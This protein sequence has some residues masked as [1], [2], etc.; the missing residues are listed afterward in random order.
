MLLGLMPVTECFCGCTLYERDNGTDESPTRTGY[1]Y[2]SGIFG[3][4]GRY[5]GKY[6]I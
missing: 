5:A 6:S 1:C 3:Y 2:A 4:N